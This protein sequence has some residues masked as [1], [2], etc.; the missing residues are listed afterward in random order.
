MVNLK[1]VWRFL[2]KD[3]SLLSWVINVIVA[4][5]LVKFIIY[6]GLGL[7]MGTG[8]PVVAVVSGSMDHGGNFD[9]W[10][11]IQS[12]WYLEKG[13]GKNEFLKFPFKNGFNK[14]DIMI[15]VGGEIEDLEV[16]DVIVFDG[17]S[18][19]P[20]IHRIVD[21]YYEGGKWYVSTKGDHNRDSHT[22]LGEEKINQ[23]RMIGRAV[24]RVPFLGWVKILAIEFFG[25]FS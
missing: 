21:K 1:K 20:I 3:D 19:N 24:F 22:A 17:A 15:L 12:E 11:D 6:P 18:A 8:Y 7:L 2:W 10:W 4:F 13:I 23:S 5:V 9:D 14:G 16:G 25:V